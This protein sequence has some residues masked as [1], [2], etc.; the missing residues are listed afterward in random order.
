VG[1]AE[2][3]RMQCS[4][5][6]YILLTPENYAMYFFNLLRIKCLYMFRVILS[7][8]Q[9]APHKRHFVYCMCVMSIGCTRI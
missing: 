8:P 2:P 6:N 5:P 7:H 1:Q 9:E 4:P 3:R